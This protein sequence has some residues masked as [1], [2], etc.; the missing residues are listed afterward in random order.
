VGLRKKAVFVVGFCGCFFASFFMFATL[1]L[2]QPS[3]SV[4]LL[5]IPHL[6]REDIY[7]MHSSSSFPFLRD[8]AIGEM[9]MRTA[10]SNKDIHTT[11]TLSTGVHAAGSEWARHMYGI[12]EQKGK[13]RS[14]YQQYMG[15]LPNGIKNTAVLF[16]YSAVLR[17]TN[18]Q[19]NTGAIPGLL[20]GTLEK[21]G[22]SRAVIGN[23]D[24]VDTPNRLAPLFTMNRQGITPDGWI[25]EETLR[26]SPFFPG[27][28]KTNYSFVTYHVKRW[29]EQG[30]R[31]IVVELG[32]LARLTQYKN[33]IDTRRYEGLRQQTIQE[34]MKFVATILSNRGAQERVLLLSPW[35]SPEDI[36]AKK[37][38]AP[39]LLWEEAGKGKVLTSATTRQ[40]GLIANVD[41]APSIFSWL[42]V[43]PAPQMKG[44]PLTL[45]A[46][47]SPEAFFREAKKIDYIYATRPAVL[48][49]YVSIIIAV[50]LFASVLLIFWKRGNKGK[51]IL[52]SFLVPSL[53]VI[54]LVPFL[55]LVFPVL[56]QL[57]SPFYT[58]LLLGAVGLLLA[59]IL[60]KGDFVQFFLWIG[61]L[62]WVPVLLD[63]IAGAE[64]MKRSY[65]GYDPV[66]GA[67][68]YGIGNEYMGVVLGS[69][70][71]SLSMIGERWGKDRRKAFLI[72]VV[73]AFII[74]TWYM[75]WP[76]G[77][78]KAGG[79]LVFLVTAVYALPAFAGGRWRLSQ[80]ILIGLVFFFLACVL[81]ALNYVASGQQQSHIGRAVS[82]LVQG[83]WGEIVRII[84]RKLTM[85]WRLIL[86]S[87]WS[88]LFIVSLL[89]S[90][91]ILS[92]RIHG[93][94]QI[95]QHHPYFMTGVKAI[96]L[97]S[98]VAL[99]VNDSGII[100]A[101]L[102][103]LYGLLPLLYKLLYLLR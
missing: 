6:T 38:M 103:M 86:A 50:I 74:L 43:S 26:S 1:A 15:P 33:R 51:G 76:E 45:D 16:P 20:G 35:L 22:V 78:S 36:K 2:P 63:G 69:S 77:G 65:L 55:L 62:N 19:K 70:L 61:L 41:I 101:A 82:E 59:S 40:P 34:M 53:P 66:I 54:L 48:Y 81:F 64:W 4:T 80:F 3:S 39:V 27:G 32:D 8:A 98:F 84:E 90:V 75:A 13:G 18:E 94:K 21:N 25:G 85:N 46:S 71:L 28:K 87:I 12:S 92:Y 9:N 23:S 5:L 96:A 42:G 73:V 10:V 88:K 31:F 97:G 89:T 95:L 37:R 68:Y 72:L 79:I 91:L 11:L 57:P 29:K 24:T 93:I 30:T 67:R 47:L 44:L 102:A 7:I 58:V 83:N 60:P 100:A 52:I 99:L 17:K 49:P 56:P 14:L